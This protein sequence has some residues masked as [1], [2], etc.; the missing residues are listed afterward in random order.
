M[1]EGRE[2]KGGPEEMGERKVGFIKR[3]QLPTTKS[4]RSQVR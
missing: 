3:G 1:E 2:K 4:M